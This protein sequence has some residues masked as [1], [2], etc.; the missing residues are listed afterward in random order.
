LY[1]S[2]IAARGLIRATRYIG[3][4]CKTRSPPE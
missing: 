1:Y 4:V 3:L 2:E